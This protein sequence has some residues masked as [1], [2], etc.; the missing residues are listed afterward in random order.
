MLNY[1]DNLEEDKKYIMKYLPMLDLRELKKAIA[2]YLIKSEKTTE[3]EKAA[4]KKYE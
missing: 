1:N 2:S 3:Q 4:L